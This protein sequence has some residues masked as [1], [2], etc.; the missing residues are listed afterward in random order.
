MDTRSETRAINIRF[1]KRRFTG[2]C[3]PGNKYP[4]ILHAGSESA[5]GVPQ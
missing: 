1:S 5:Y 2:L 4:H 3:T